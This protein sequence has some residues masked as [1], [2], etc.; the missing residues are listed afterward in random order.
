M[1]AN[2]L[3]YLKNYENTLFYRTHPLLV[4]TKKFRYNNNRTY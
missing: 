4:K 2:A 3:I 1:R